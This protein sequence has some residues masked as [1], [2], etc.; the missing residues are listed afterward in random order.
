[1]SDKAT[2]PD[3]APSVR[4]DVC[5]VCTSRISALFQEYLN[6]VPTTPVYTLNGNNGPRISQVTL[7]DCITS[8][9]DIVD[10]IHL[11]CQLRGDS[12]V[13]RRPYQNC[14]F[15]TRVPLVS[16]RAGECVLV[17][18]LLRS[19]IIQYA[20]MHWELELRPVYM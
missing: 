14:Y 7:I 15:A 3:A 11:Y 4:S 19:S 16:E 20:L 13:V 12:L 17:T 5:Y 18:D 8:C 2:I 9:W 10:A 1:M 6:R